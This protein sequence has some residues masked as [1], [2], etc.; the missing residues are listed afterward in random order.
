MKCLGCF[1]NH[2]R[3]KRDV[4]TGAALT[5]AVRDTSRMRLE[6]LWLGAADAWF[7]RFARCA[8]RGGAVGITAVAS[9]RVAVGRMAVRRMAI[10]R[11]AIGAV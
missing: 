5:V 4:E 2:D 10:G 9:T 8:I 6:V 11:M 1:P 7:L 3:D